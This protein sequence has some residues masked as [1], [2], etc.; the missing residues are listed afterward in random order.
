MDL[1][2]AGLLNRRTALSR[3]SPASAGEPNRLE[4][5]KTTRDEIPRTRG[6]PRTVGASWAAAKIGRVPASARRMAPTCG[7]GV[8]SKEER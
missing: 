3:V 8:Q 2:L 1:L 4:L 5:A 7:L 6:S